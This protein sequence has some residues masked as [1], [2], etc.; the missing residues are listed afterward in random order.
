MNDEE[1][2]CGTEEKEESL[3]LE[4]VDAAGFQEGGRERGE[5]GYNMGGGRG[6]GRRGGS[7]P[8]ETVEEDGQDACRGRYIHIYIG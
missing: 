5:R 8:G 1:E 7:E 3:R 4:E 6:G 2:G